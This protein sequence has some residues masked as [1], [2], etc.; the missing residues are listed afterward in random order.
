MRAG[1]QASMQLVDNATVRQIDARSIASGIDSLSLMEQAGRGAALD[2]LAQVG[3]HGGTT[4]VVCG[5]GNNGGDG[6]VF[7][8]VLGEVGHPVV[9]FF[10]GGEPTPDCATNLVRAREAGIEIYDDLGGALASIGGRWVVDALLGSGFAPPLRE[11]MATYARTL[12]ECGRRVYALDA[13]TGIDVDTGAADPDT[14]MAERTAVFGPPRL[15]MFRAPARA[16]CGRVILVDPGFDPEVVEAECRRFEPCVG[17]VDRA[18][19]AAR[20]SRRAIDAHKYRVGSVLVVAG[21]SGM[22]GAAA[23]AAAAAHRGGAGLVEVLTPAPVAA[24]IDGLTPESLVRGLAA[25]ESGGFA[26]DVI[27]GI[28]QCAARRSAVLLGCGV[29]EDPDTAGLMVELCRRIEVPLVVDADGLN[30]FGRTGADVILPATSVL[31]PHAGELARLLDRAAA[32]I[33][34]DRLGAAHDAVA[35]FGCTVLLKGAPTAVV[36]PD[37]RAALIGSGGPELA[38]AGSGDVL[39]GVIV[40]LLASGLGPFDAATCGAWVHGRAGE[41]LVEEFGIVGV[42]AGDLVEEVARVGREL[43]VHA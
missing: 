5:R 18:H 1:E 31:T 6:L 9:V 12:R 36:S 4:L 2:F 29:G 22:S 33:E 23:L 28:L 3:E 14:P 43:E 13:P 41:R 11:P 24:V 15:G 34:A 25:T 32:D 42:V 19:A 40:A 21:S 10:S 39:A 20:W 30:A 8:R 26:P 7:A 37:G 27:D 16:H 17:W 35:R 38:T